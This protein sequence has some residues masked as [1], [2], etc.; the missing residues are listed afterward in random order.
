MSD[1][2][3]NSPLKP[4]A[5][6]GRG[7]VRR[8]ERQRALILDAATILLNQRGVRGMT[9]LEVAQAVQLTPTSVTYY[10]R[11]KE[12]L[13]A[14]VFEDSLALLEAMAIEAAAEATPQA[15]VARYIHLHFDL[16]ARALRGQARPLAILSEIRA[17]EEET[18]RPVIA[19]YQQV[20]RVVRGF[21]GKPAS[22]AQKA[23]FTA[24]TQM[25]NEAIFWSAIWLNNY[26][27]SDFS[28]VATLMMAI[29]EHG[30]A[31]AG[32]AWVPEMADPVEIAAEQGSR[33]AFLRIA[34]R[35]INDIG[36]RGT[37][38]DRI[39]AELNLT[40]GSFY[41]HL[42]AKDDLVLAC[43]RDSY[44]RIMKLQQIA[45]DTGGPQWYRLASII[46]RAL[47]IQFEGRHPLLRTTALQALPVAVRSM[48]LER[49][50]RVALRFAGV[51]I[52]GM[53]DGSI[54]IL[55][56]L[57]A[58]QMIMSTIN[59]AYDIHNWAAKL[60]PGQAIA[61]Y[62]STLMRGIFDEVSSIYP[63]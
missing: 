59:A 6:G 11:Y 40:K 4:L 63:E 20:F 44:R 58:S 50:N 19:R 13:A 42:E 62:G 34:T 14:A 5:E 35:L 56:P 24:R 8:F 21:F 15:R 17:L 37:S 23:L 30:I 60:S 12:Q 45:D 52:D 33:S 27:I 31:V 1:S 49:A 48:A 39:V 10:F 55:D 22:E 54:R 57:I 43:F 61:T 2:Q 38:V 9:F 26:A 18:R 3:P 25:L 7:P 32:S 51:L 53:Q 29:L 28:R 41:H 47:K 16:H 46:A 36:Y